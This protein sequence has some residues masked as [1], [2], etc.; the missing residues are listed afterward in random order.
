MYR[1]Y[2]I[3]LGLLTTMLVGIAAAGQTQTYR[4]DIMMVVE[5]SKTAVGETFT[6]G[7]EQPVLAADAYSPRA[8]KLLSDV[9]IGGI[10]SAVNFKKG[11][12]LFGRYDK[13]I[14][15]YCGIGEHNTSS[16]AL[17]TVVLG[18]FTG[19]LSLL[20]GY[21]DTE[22]KCLF[23]ADDDGKFDS[24]WTGGI[25][26]SDTAMVAFSLRKTPMS[27]KPGYE[28]AKYTKGPVMPVEIKWTKNPKTGVITFSTMAGGI[29]IQKRSIPVPAV[30]AG[31]VTHRQ[32]GAEIEVISYDGEADRLTYQIKTGTKRSYF[33]V[34]AKKVITTQVIYY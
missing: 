31:L 2:M 34:P 26:E 8:V 14:W 4:T 9:T 20:S 24:A 28:K 15:T 12:V 10:D 32:F 7:P 11:A 30:G 3:T 5:P 27:A 21:D 13:S 1:I 22:I 23:D 18:V 6:I 19:G 29:S 33:L 16:K 25:A 17:N